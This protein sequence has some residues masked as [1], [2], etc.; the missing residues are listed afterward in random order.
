MS[1][2]VDWIVNGDVLMIDQSDGRLMWS[3]RARFVRHANRASPVR[4]ARHVRRA[5]RARHVRRGTRVKLRN[6]VGKPNR[7]SAKR[8]RRR[9]CL[10]RRKFLSQVTG[11][12]W[13]ISSAGCGCVRMGRPPL[14]RVVVDRLIPEGEALKRVEV[15][16]GNVDLSGAEVAIRLVVDHVCAAC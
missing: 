9:S 2:V 6:R 11:I 14:P 15:Q 5:R 12:V 16:M 1:P 7:L 8:C 3:R 13:M 10:S 4:H